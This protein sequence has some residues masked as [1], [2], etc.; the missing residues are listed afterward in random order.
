MGNKIKRYL[1]F[2]SPIERWGVPLRVT[3]RKQYKYRLQRIRMR[4]TMHR[5]TKNH[6]GEPVMY[7][8]GY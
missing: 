8:R 2:L 3:Q 5:I 6:G 1:A 7:G 4:D